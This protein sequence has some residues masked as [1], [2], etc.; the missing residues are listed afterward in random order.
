MRGVILKNMEMCEQASQQHSRLVLIFDSSRK[1]K[2]LQFFGRS[3]MWMRT[4]CDMVNAS[5]KLKMLIWK[6]SLKS[7]K[8]L[9]NKD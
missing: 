2:F 6:N 4:T 1:Y 8:L 5:A 9:V 3:F 7:R